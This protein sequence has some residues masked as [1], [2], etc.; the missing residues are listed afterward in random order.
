MP[1]RTLLPALLALAASLSAPGQ[2]TP[3]KPACSTDPKSSNPCPT[4]PPAAPAQAF[5]YPGDS[6]S[7]PAPSQTPARQF[8][9]PGDAQPPAS[10]TS[11][12]QPFPFPG[13]KSSG[14][15][16]PA[17]QPS[18]DSSA[19]SSSSSSSNSSDP[20]DPLDPSSSTPAPSATGNTVRRKLPKPTHLQ[21]DEEREAE[22][23]KVAQFY[24]DSGNTLGAYNR[25]KDAIKLAQ[26]DADA[27]YLL[28]SVA[29][30]LGKQPESLDA[31]TKF[32]ALEPDTRRAKSL[33][34]T[35]ED[36]QAKK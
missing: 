34:H 23:V 20:D 5:P 22:D 8:P 25:L 7:A 18:D 35:L 3:A 17:G 13:D 28:G 29:S 32:L 1:P 33:R 2:G 36:T 30:R 4:P 6:P 24:S 31:Y 10:P 16:T 9:S 26:D 14:K 27:F 12:N 19:S 21:S 11:P 15:K